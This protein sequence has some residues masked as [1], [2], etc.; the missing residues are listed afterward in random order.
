MWE[1]INVKTILLILFFALVIFVILGVRHPAR[2]QENT[3]VDSK[4]T[5]LMQG[6]EDFTGI[7]VEVKILGTLREN[8]ESALAI[9]SI[10]NAFILSAD[11]DFRLVTLRS[12]LSN[13]SDPNLGQGLEVVVSILQSKAFSADLESTVAVLFF[14]EASSTVII[15]P[16]NEDIIGVLTAL[17][18][19]IFRSTSET[20]AQSFSGCSASVALTE[21]ILRLPAE[22]IRVCFHTT[23]E[24]S[25]MK[26][27]EITAIPRSVGLFADLKLWPEAPREGVITTRYC[28]A[29][30]TFEVKFLAANITL[31]LFEAAFGFTIGGFVNAKADCNGRIQTRIEM[32]D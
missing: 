22:Q 24:D 6:I 28:E 8:Q 13:S 18:R 25:L 1:K 19:R 11:N 15:P 9:T 14:G 3:I 31:L 21:N 4:L 20:N 26:T 30:E 7:P 2:S 17:S 23:C 29:N 16:D 5:D 27:C 32:V 10:D 12:L